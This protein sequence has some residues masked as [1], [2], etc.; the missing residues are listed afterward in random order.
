MSSPASLLATLAMACLC[1][2]A[3]AA[4]E[5]I[6]GA[7]SD[8]PPPVPGRAPTAALSDDSFAATRERLVD[9]WLALTPSW[10]REAGLHRYDGKIADY[11]PK[12]IAR[13]RRW[14]A[15]AQS[16]LEA[17][18]PA[19]LATEEALDLAVLQSKL[20]LE[21]FVID[22]MANPETQPLFYTELFDVSGY[23]VFDYA[24]IEWR[25]RSLVSHEK[26]ALRQVDHLL[27]N[28]RPT[29]SR[30]I[31]E[32]A[33]G[34]YEGYR[35]Y[36]RVD[37]PRAVAEVAD[38]QLRARFEESNSALAKRAD[39]VVVALREQFLP[40]AD[41]TSHVLGPKRFLAFVA[42]QEGMQ[43][44]L[45]DFERMADADLE[46]NKR[47]YLDLSSRIRL[48]RPRADQLLSAARDMVS[49]SRA[50]VVDEQLVSIPSDELCAV[51]ETPPFMR[52]NAAFLNMP[53]PF[54]RAK[55]AYYYITPPNPA[56]PEDKQ[57][58]YVFPQGVLR[59]TT[60]HE[61]WPGHFLQGLWQRRAPT[62]VQRLVD[63]YSFTEGWAH[64]VEQM[65]IDEGFGASDPQSRLGQLSDA[66]LR[67]C[68]FVVSIGVHAHG[69]SLDEAA[70]RFREDCMQ[71][72][73]SAEQ[74]AVRAAFDPGYFA[75]TLGKLQILEL[76]EELKR[77]L[78]PRFDLRLF[79]D[80]L[81][82][83]G[84]PPLAL[85]RERVAE[86]VRAGVR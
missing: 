13:Y 18:D 41:N 54:D 46:R 83:H 1:G 61:V 11:R 9:Q 14:L 31:V 44:D 19:K 45:D 16:A 48:T 49:S 20:A 73:A 26:A 24:P 81:L 47:A 6:E 35:D 28:L 34:V 43:V 69:M 17:F 12:G 7:P 67:N 76:R 68:R 21:R 36:L 79:H 71:D 64:Y 84:A 50:F 65:M 53:G 86:T 75:Y 78:G 55:Q 39:D 66:L 59:A 51:R 33:I 32:T 57:R 42:A 22:E 70:K 74:Q 5:P 29:L 60:V 30:P 27:A 77:E 37:V 52:W 85:I 38:P 56:W 63:S 62:R 23:L 72:A 2:C 25:V 4:W 40:R 80:A 8:P 10:G 58:D 82:S 3:G 15:A